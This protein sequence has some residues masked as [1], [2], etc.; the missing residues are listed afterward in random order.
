MTTIWKFPV[1]VGVFKLEMPIRSRVLSVG[2]QN[3]EPML[4]AMV[5]ESPAEAKWFAGAMTG[6]PL[7]EKP[8]YYSKFIGT[9]LLHGDR[10][11]LHLF[12]LH[13]MGNLGIDEAPA[14]D[15]VVTVVT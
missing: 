4:W 3:G 9:V 13:F 2:A 6:Q 5:T 10:L 12:Q 7:P 15:E 14:P 8:G 11:V 1:S